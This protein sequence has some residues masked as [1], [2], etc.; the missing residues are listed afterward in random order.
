VKNTVLEGRA[1]KIEKADGTLIPNIDTD[2]IFHNK[3]LA[4]TKISE[5]GPLAFGNLDGWKDFPAR[6]APGDILI[7]GENFGC[8]SSRQQAVDC[9]I[10]LGVSALVGKSFGAIYYRNAVNSALPTLEAA[11]IDKDAISTGDKIR[12]N[13]ETG[14]IENLTT[15]KKLSPAKPFSGVQMDIYQSG[16][17]FNYAKGTH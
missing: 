9:F 3:H 17:I 5:M 11:N 2:M 15:G 10:A 6:V 16:S 8:G 4:I 12:I 14:E 1:I 7:L 13:F